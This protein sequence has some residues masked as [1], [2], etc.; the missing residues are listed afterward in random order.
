[1]HAADLAVA[2]GRL[3]AGAAIGFAPGAAAWR[4]AEIAPLVAGR[5]HSNTGHEVGS[6]FSQVGGVAR[7]RRRA[8]AGEIERRR[9]AGTRD[10]VEVGQVDLH[11]TKD[12][13][14]G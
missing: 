3:V 14:F 5:P 11:G 1:M 4:E 12:N 10:A 2:H 6:G 9:Q 7:L 8:Q 13:L